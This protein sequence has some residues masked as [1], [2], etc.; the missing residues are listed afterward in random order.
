MILSVCGLICND[1]EFLGKSCNGCVE[2][3]GS[4]FW[5]QEMIPDKVCPL[6]NC[7][8]N[9]KNY[10]HCGSCEELPCK[11]FLEMK[12]PDLSDEEHMESINVRVRRLR[13]EN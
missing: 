5:A 11:L 9:V 6:Y 12:D 1:C 3:K 4:T 7:A 2:V 13:G 8:V 10:N